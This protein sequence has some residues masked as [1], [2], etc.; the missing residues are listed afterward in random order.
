MAKDKKQESA[1]DGLQGLQELQKIVEAAA[2]IGRDATTAELTK[3]LTVLLEESAQ[4]A[5]ITGT[6]KASALKTILGFLF[7][8]KTKGEN[9]KEENKDKSKTKPEAKPEAKPEEKPDLLAN[10]LKKYKELE[11]ERDQCVAKLNATLEKN[12]SLRKILEHAGIQLGNNNDNTTKTTQRKSKLLNFLDNVDPNDP[13]TVSLALDVAKTEISRLTNEINLLKRT[14]EEEQSASKS[15]SEKEDDLQRRIDLLLFTSREQEGIIKRLELNLQQ[16]E[17]QISQIKNATAGILTMKEE[18][19]EDA[20]YFAQRIQ[21]TVEAVRCV[22]DGNTI[23]SYFT[24]ETTQGISDECLL[25]CDG[26]QP[27]ILGNIT[28]YATTIQAYSKLLEEMNQADHM[29]SLS[30]F[31]KSLEILGKLKALKEIQDQLIKDTINEQAGEN[32][33]Q[34]Q[35]EQSNDIEDYYDILEIN[36]SATEEEIRKA[37]YEKAKKYHPDANNGAEETAEKF[38]KAKEAYDILSDQEK[39]YEYDRSRERKA[40]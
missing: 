28:L 35:E 29:P 39:R 15:T 21:S 23:A 24:F 26:L 27:N 6:T 8:K 36:P 10:I 12:A 40:A 4:I 31:K 9:D 37:Y 20:Q 11:T 5:E 1:H 18:L 19:L 38:M 13:A 32:Q 17:W 30:L 2:E 33:N 7:G 3:Q 25:I 34:Q 16:K 22:Y 14:L